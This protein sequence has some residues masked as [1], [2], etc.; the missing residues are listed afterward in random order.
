MQLEFWKIYCWIHILAW[1]Y[2]NCIVIHK[3]LVLSDSLQYV[4]CVHIPKFYRLFYRFLW[5]DTVEFNRLQCANDKKYADAI[6]ADRIR[7]QLT[8]FRFGLLSSLSRFLHVHIAYETDSAKVIAFC[9][10]SYCLPDSIRLNS[11]VCNVQ[12]T[13][14]TMMWFS[15]IDSDTNWKCLK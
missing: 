9:R 12:T 5:F 3:A 14:C 13:W 4:H 11:I 6:F 8:M 15:P 7:Y 2:H 1:I 10:N